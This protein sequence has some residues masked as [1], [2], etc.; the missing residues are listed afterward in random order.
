VFQTSKI[1]IKNAKVEMNHGA[2]G[3]AMH[4][5]IQ[6]LFMTAFNNP[7][8]AQQNDQACFN[9]PINRLAMTTDSYVI[10]PIFFPGGNIG[11]LAVHG[12][13]NDLA[14]S[15]AIPLYLSVGFILEEGYPLANLKII[16]DAMAKAANQAN[17]QIITGD[18]KVVEKG[19]GDGVFINTTGIGIIDDH[20]KLTNQVNPGDKIIVSGY[21]GDHGIAVMSKRENLQFT[22]AIESDSAALH[23]LTHHMF[24]VVPDIH[25]LR[26]P[27]RGG[28]AATL[29]EWA[30]QYQVGISID[31][32]LIPIR[33]PVKGACELLGIDPLYVANEGKLVVICSAD[34][35]EILLKAMQQHPLAQDAAMIGEVIED[36]DCFVQM[37]TSFGGTRI[38][39]WLAGEQL[40]RIC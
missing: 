19:K 8:L 39:D 28:L 13:I 10:S 31:E 7:I 23:E 1:S 16:V 14:M 25:C 35:A 12:T 40:P 9:V 21:I 6:Q 26:D 17:V 34:K 38:V 32:S 3:K 5:L 18:T 27:T 30:K 37:Q 33:A 22:T 24:E 4:T 20:I 11:S 29:N 36:P 15:G 2:G